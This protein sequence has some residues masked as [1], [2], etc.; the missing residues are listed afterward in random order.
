MPQAIRGER[1]SPRLALA[2][3]CAGQMLIVLE[4]NIVNVALPDLQRSLGFSSANLVWVVNAYLVPFGGLL[5]LAGRLG[6]LVG[7]RTVFLTGVALFSTASLLCGF[8]TSGAALIGFRFAQGIG[9]AVASACILGM[10]AT[11]APEPRA[12]AQAIA[13]YS[14]ASAGGG[15]VGPPIGGALTDLV[16]WNWIFFINAPVGAAVIVGALR[17]LPRDTG[18]GLVRGR[19]VDVPGA[20]LVTAGLM[21]FVFTIVNAG[22]VGWRAGE[23]LLLGPLS[24][25]LLAGFLAREAT[26]A[27]PLLPLA[28][29]RSRTVAA[30]NL[31]QFLLIAG[32]FGLLFYGTLYVQRVLGYTSL[33]AGLAF[34]P[35]AVVIAAF[36]LGLSARMIMRFGP[37]VLLLGGLALI[38][39]AF[40]GLSLTRADGTYLV[41]V[42]PA[43]VLMGIGVGMAIPAVMGLGMSAVE[44]EASGV[45]SGLF[46]TSQQI[47]GAIGLTVLSAVVSART[48]SL[49]DSAGASETSALLGGYH[50]G[51]LVAA[52]FTCSAL[53][54]T[55]TVLR[56][57]RGTA[58]D[59][60]DP[61]AEPRTAD[62]LPALPVTPAEAV[63]GPGLHGA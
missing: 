57:P 50:L 47:G 40:G 28:M 29:L 62:G 2:V 1:G 25:V 17:A 32:M 24:I 15:A 22:Q 10:V 54:V 18:P 55:L 44:P 27:A 19:S 23:T 16:S 63:T 5:M 14:F 52:G 38:T 56:V 41:D 8:A 4:Q 37:W 53:L 43:T 42:L 58:T 59:I 26:A 34:V 9:G 49:A 12:Q 60:R 46:N 45:A 31:V 13:A 51:F 11:M 48:D 39:L 7:R 3:L 6:D 33:Q 30:A 21:L 36:S 35:I 20:A 61:V